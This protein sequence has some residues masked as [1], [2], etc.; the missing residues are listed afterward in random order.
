[1]VLERSQ[2]GSFGEALQTTFDGLHPCQ[3]CKV[4]RAGKSEE[5]KSE[6]QIKL[7]KLEVAVPEESFCLFTPPEPDLGLPGVTSLPVFRAEAPP[8]PPPRRA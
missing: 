1:M 7:S 4:V 5:Q 6:R 3:L 8:I 2:T